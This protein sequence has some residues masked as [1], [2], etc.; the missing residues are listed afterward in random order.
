MADW[1]TG[2]V[3]CGFPVQI[4][5]MPPSTQTEISYG[6]S[7][8]VQ[9][10]P[11][12]YRHEAKTT[13]FRFLEFIMNQSSYF[14]TPC[15]SDT[16]DSGKPVKTQ[17]NANRSVT[18]DLDLSPHGQTCWWIKRF[19]RRYAVYLLGNLSEA[20]AKMKRVK[21]EATTD[22]ATA[23]QEMAVKGSTGVSQPA[24]SWG[25][26]A[27]QVMPVRMYGWE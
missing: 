7:P 18:L 10:R 22:T 23:A 4:S 9:V 21:A 14:S 6:F 20:V 19:W 11:G 15:S 13:L 24:S 26:G 12:Q 16:D 2:P 17:P 3:F 1:W 27:M 25:L 8:A 5:D